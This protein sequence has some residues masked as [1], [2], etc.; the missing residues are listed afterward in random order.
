[1][2]RVHSRALLRIHIEQRQ[3]NSFQFYF[4]LLI[5]SYIFDHHCIA[6][7][8]RLLFSL[9]LFFPMSNLIRC[10]NECLSTNKEQRGSVNALS[11]FKWQISKQ[12]RNAFNSDVTKNKIEN[13]IYTESERM[14][15]GQV[16]VKVVPHRKTNKKLVRKL[17]VVSF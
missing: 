6:Y 7:G 1:M 2:W 4:S 12:S 11:H 13:E 9:S 5:F 17:N 8:C 3:L 15:R 10:F 14:K 16:V